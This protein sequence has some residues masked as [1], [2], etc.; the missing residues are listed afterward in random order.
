MLVAVELKCLAGVVVALAPRGELGD[1]IV[2]GPPA[3]PGFEPGAVVVVAVVVAARA[4]AVDLAEE[5][6]L[7]VRPVLVELGLVVGSGAM[8]EEV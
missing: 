5:L 7:K 3:V 4:Q 1:P 8:R 6:A 2:L